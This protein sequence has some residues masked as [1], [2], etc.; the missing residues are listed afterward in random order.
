MKEIW[1][2]IPGYEGLYQ[3]SNLGRVKSFKQ[4]TKYHKTKEY[5]LT[6][7]IGYHGYCQVTLYGNTRKKFLVHRLV[8]GAFIPNPDHLPAVNHKDEDPTNNRAD[9]L[10]WCTTEYNNA[11]GT[12][13]IRRIDTKSK[14]VEQL[15]LDGK[16]IAIYRSSRIASELLGINLGTFKDYIRRKVPCQGYCWKYSNYNF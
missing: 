2:N 9:N 7:S 11:Y 13:K 5:I 3:I 4:S 8:A 12:A 1:Q 15:T 10:E 14:P 6:P 16:I